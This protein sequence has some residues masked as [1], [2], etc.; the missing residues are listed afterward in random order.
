M[1]DLRCPRGHLKCPMWAVGSSM[2]DLEVEVLSAN[3]LSMDPSPH[4]ATTINVRFA[5]VAVLMEGCGSELV[6]AYYINNISTPGPTRTNQQPTWD[7]SRVPG[8][9]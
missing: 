7:T 2:L 5:V 4:R 6:G 9:T 3:Q 1:V 8:D